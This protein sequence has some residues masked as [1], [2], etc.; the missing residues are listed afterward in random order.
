MPTFREIHA[1]NVLTYEENAS[2]WDFQ[3]K[4][5]FIEKSWI[6][7]L[8]E[9]L[10]DG[11]TVLDVGCG[12][13][14]PIAQYFIQQRFSY[15]GVD[16]SR[17]MLQIARERFPDECWILM[18]MRELQLARSFDGI[19]AWDS[20]FH[21]SPDE[22]RTTLE[23]FCRHLKAGGALLMTIGDRAG[24]VLGTVNGAEVYHS[25]LEP[26]EYQR[27]LAGFG[28]SRVVIVPRDQTCGGRT[29]LLAAEFHRSI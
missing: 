1:R 16:A 7:R 5:K 29:V 18:D 27:L 4:G 23:R 9:C 2:A 8:A 20:F 22:Q 11:A 12:A 19:I 28:F 17:A 6:E 14:I 25:S 3:R 10:P 21:L 26:A 13:G 24:E 15:T